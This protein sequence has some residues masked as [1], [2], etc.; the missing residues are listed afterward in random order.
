MS[1]SRTGSRGSP[2][3]VSSLRTKRL[4]KLLTQGGKITAIR[5]KGKRAHLNQR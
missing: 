2:K 4:K 3:K 1:T 5:F